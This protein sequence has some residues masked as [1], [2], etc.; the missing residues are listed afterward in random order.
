MSE[1]PQG[2]LQRKQAAGGRPGLGRAA[3]AEV[4]AEVIPKPKKYIPNSHQEPREL[5]CAP[6]AT[7]KQSF[8]VH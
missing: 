6:P 4:G 3:Y 8:F 7:P 5:K 1:L 2:G